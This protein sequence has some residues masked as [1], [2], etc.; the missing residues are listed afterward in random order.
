MDI[1]IVSKRESQGLRLI[2]KCFVPP[3]LTTLLPVV[4]NIKYWNIMRCGFG[5]GFGEVEQPSEHMKLKQ[6]S[7]EFNSKRKVHGK[8]LYRWIKLKIQTFSFLLEMCPKEQCPVFWL[9]VHNVK[10]IVNVQVNLLIPSL[11]STAAYKWRNHGE[12]DC[13]RRLFWVSQGH[14]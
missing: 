9:H 8:V 6:D 3:P 10:L 7:F 11:L 13:C 2:G 4:R 1:G 5:T 14:K 12:V